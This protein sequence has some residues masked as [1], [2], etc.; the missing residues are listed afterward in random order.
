[1]S[2]E[3]YRDFARVF[4]DSTPI[5]SERELS[6]AIAAAGLEQD[7]VT[8]KWLASLRP[9]WVYGNSE[10]PFANEALNRRYLRMLF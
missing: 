6:A 3:A 7:Q 10:S 4:A 8:R 5:R 9:A 2:A 1:M